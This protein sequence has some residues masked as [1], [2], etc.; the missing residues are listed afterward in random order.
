MTGQVVILA[1]GLGTRL[2]PITEAIPKPMAPV[3]GRPF[4]HWQLEDLRRQGFRRVVL[5]TAYLGEQIERYFRGGEA[6]GIEVRA[7]REPEP[8]GT[9]GALKHARDVLD[10]RFVLLNGDSFLRC[11]LGALLA[12]LDAGDVDAVM[13]TFAD[14]D[15][16]PVIP[17]VRSDGR[18]VLGY[19]K[20]AG[21]ERG[22]ALIDA[23]AYAMRRELVDTIAS[24]A[25][26][27]AD[28][29]PPLIARGRL[30]AM[31]VSERFYDIGTPARL[32]EFEAA[33]H[34][35][36]DHGEGAA[37]ERAR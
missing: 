29:W 21:T 15:A 16:V 19:E 9:G 30:G 14:R 32:A 26:A 31:P 18:R 33:V 3:A 27:L 34:R 12:R 11:D 20:D 28:L 25:F 36:F 4:L 24:R 17:N 2:R 22:F 7:V 6:Y 23:G 8:L 5:L 37:R 10:E 35:Y 1:G 13:T